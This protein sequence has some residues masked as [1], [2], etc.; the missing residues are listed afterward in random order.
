MS[1]QAKISETMAH[2]ISPKHY[3]ALL[4]SVL[5]LTVL[6]PIVEHFIWA[7]I[8]IGLMMVASL[9]TA[10]L[11]VKSNHRISLIAFSLACLSG[12]MWILAFCDHFS[13]CN[14]AGFQIAAYAVTFLFFVIICCIILQDVFQG[15]VDANKICGSVCVYLLIGFCFSMLHMMIALSDHN[16]YRNNIFTADS[17]AHTQTY[18]SY[19]ERYPL[20]VYFSF[21]T[22][23]TLGYG[24]IVPVS[25]LA[26]SL[27]FLEATL[28]QLYLAVLVAR[29][30]GL[31]TASIT[32]RHRAETLSAPEERELVGSL[33]D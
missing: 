5:G 31:H 32:M 33:L 21:C 6:A 30:V 2:C 18:G 25:R 4:S 14:S 11:A 28:G 12:I 7:K 3:V 13:P 23:S 16:A 19:V 15:S 8:T 24:D 9:L 17:T 29:L 10:A 26:R 1:V 27:S 22:F 20:F